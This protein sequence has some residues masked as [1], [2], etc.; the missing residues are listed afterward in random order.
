[1][2]NNRIGIFMNVFVLFLAIIIPAQTYQSY[3]TGGQLPP[4]ELPK[5]LASPVQSVIIPPSLLPPSLNYVSLGCV[6][7]VKNQYKGYFCW[8][9]ASAAVYESKI[10]MKEWGE[11]DIS[12]QQEISCNTTS[13][14]FTWSMDFWMNNYPMLEACT[15]YPCKWGCSPPPQCS[16]FQGCTR[17]D[18]PLVSYFYG[19]SSGQQDQEII[20]MKSSLYLDGPA[21]VHMPNFLEFNP[22]DGMG[23]WNLGTINGKRYPAYKNF[24]TSHE[25]YHNIMIC[26]W[27][28]NK[29]V[30]PYMTPPQKGA[31]LCKNSW[32]SKGGPDGNG[33]FW[34][35]YNGHAYP[36]CL[37][38]MYNA[39]VNGGNLLMTGTGG[40]QDQIFK[41]GFNDQ[42][43][44]YVP[45]AAVRCCGDGAGN[46][47]VIDRGGFIY[48]WDRGKNNWQNVP[49]PVSNS[50][51]IDISQAWH[52][53]E[54]KWPDYFGFKHYVY[55]AAMHVSQRKYLFRL[56]DDGTATYIQAITPKK[57]DVGND[58]TVF[59]IQD[60]SQRVY[61]LNSKN[62]PID[63]T[64]NLLGKSYGVDVGVQNAD[65]VY[66]V[67]S[68]GYLYKLNKGAQRW[69]LINTYGFKEV[70]VDNRYVY[71]LDNHLSGVW[72]M[73][74]K[75]GAWT[76]LTCCA[77]S[78]GASAY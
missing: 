10:M 49:C 37:K 53:S 36:Y 28:D 41:L 55:L 2:V 52:W 29:V 20:E 68:Y 31:W 17:T 32:G 5:A 60:G 4:E 59:Y 16:T 54:Q 7:S 51:G 24:N 27:D 26:G 73:D 6:S 9:F 48:K 1:M 64:Y 61:Y 19:V 8:A 39:R 43:L 75:S 47:W 15:G 70:D 42:G 22:Q 72:K 21:H 62:Q 23:W 77:Q 25:G 56:N 67:D 18:F 38:S 78:I 76:P 74:I 3:P 71:C 57:I 63:V 50:W 30:D 40:A 58:G 65:T 14:G 11:W 35:A 69:D 33:F 13:S 46:F 66:L 12:E 34:V 45:G 44:I